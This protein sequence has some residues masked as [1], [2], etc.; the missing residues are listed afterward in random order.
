ME[1]RYHGIENLVIDQLMCIGYTQNK[2]GI[3]VITLDEAQL[4]VSQQTQVLKFTEIILK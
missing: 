1:L 3:I 4:S 2:Y